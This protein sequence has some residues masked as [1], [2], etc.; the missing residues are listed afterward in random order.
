MGHSGTLD[1]FAEGLLILLINKSSKLSYN[2]LSMEK[3]Y[4]ANIVL[5]IKTDTWDITGK[6]LERNTVK[7]ISKKRLKEVLKSIKGDY[8]QKIPMFSAKKKMGKHLYDYA[9]KGIE[10]ETTENKVS[11]YDLK[12]ESFDLNEFCIKISCSAG[13]YIRSVASDL[14]ERLECGAVLSKLKRTRIGKFYLNN[15]A[16]LEELI[17]KYANIKYDEDLSG[18]LDCSYFIPIND[19]ADKKKTVYVYS[20]YLK[21]LADNYPLYGYMININ[22]TKQKTINENDV[23]LVKSTNRGK[24]FLHKSITRFNTGDNLA[25]GEKLTKS[26]LVEDFC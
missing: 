10:I 26:I 21:M 15:A 6:I 1:P 24:C 7:K 18:I 9:R 2:F 4:V 25:G 17:K 23:F 13:T 20:R 5:G 8:M 16:G 19:I 12:L 22:K 11:I 3:E 14:G